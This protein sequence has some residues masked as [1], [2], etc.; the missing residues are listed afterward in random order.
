MRYLST[1]AFELVAVEVENALSP[2]IEFAIDDI[3]GFSSLEA[4]LMSNPEDLEIG[5][6][7]ADPTLDDGTFGSIN[8]PAYWFDTI[9]LRLLKL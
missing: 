7:L 5:L 4:G 9:M 1:G 8:E 2:G 3:D 6:I